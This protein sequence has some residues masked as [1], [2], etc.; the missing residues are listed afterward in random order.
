M[1]RAAARTPLRARTPRP[2]RA[3]EAPDPVTTAPA[4]RARLTPEDWIAAATAV[5]VD[6]GI[7]RVRV[8]TL[9]VQLG[10]TR[11]SFYWHFRDRDH[12]LRRLLQAWSERTTEQLTRR[13]KGASTDA[14][15]RLR[16]VVSLPFRG[17][18]A[19]REARIELAIRAWARRDEMARQAV[20]TSD[21]SRIAY[22]AQ[23]FESLGFDAAQARHRGF[24]LYAYEVAESLLNRLGS[25]ALKR[26]RSAFVERLVQQPLES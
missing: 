5:L 21:A 7:D 6:Q 16:G 9:A 4:E 12:L 15:E 1:S 10:V 11:G 22:H 24:L 3:A 18:A 20:D 8:D 17:Q 13:L 26:E 2:R 19:A 23:I 25:A 14:A